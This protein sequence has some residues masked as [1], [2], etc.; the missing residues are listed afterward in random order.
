MRAFLVI[1][2]HERVE[3]LLE[4]LEAPVDLPAE[5]D[6]IE[7]V[8]HRL[9]EALADPVGLGASGL[10]LRVL[11]LVQT[12]E[13]LVRVAVETATELRPAIGQ[14]PEDPNLLILKERQ[15]AVVQSVCGGTFV[16]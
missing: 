9:V 14:D 13:D 3:I 6:P 15:R 12:Q 1:A 16:V 2:L 5:R 4:L 10:G 7:L 8:E 11:D